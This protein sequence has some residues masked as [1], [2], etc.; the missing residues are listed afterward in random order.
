MWRSVL[1]LFSRPDISL[2]SA[3]VILF[4]NSVPFYRKIHVRTWTL[5]CPYSP[6]R[7]FLRRSVLPLSHQNVRNWTKAKSSRLPFQ[8][9]CRLPL[10]FFIFSAC[11]RKPVS[12]SHQFIHPPR[13][14]LVFPSCIPP[15]L[16]VPWTVNHEQRITDFYLALLHHLSPIIKHNSTGIGRKVKPS[17][18]PLFNMKYKRDWILSESNSYIFG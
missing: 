3:S 18:A 6:L 1:R 10:L 11:L 14:F 17:R 7:F 9:G 2:Y 15:S 5:T 16:P 4:R 13:P 12:C 8:N